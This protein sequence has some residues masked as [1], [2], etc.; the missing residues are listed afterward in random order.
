MIFWGGGGKIINGVVNIM[1]PVAE[2]I[3]VPERVTT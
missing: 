3:E 1:E 2:F